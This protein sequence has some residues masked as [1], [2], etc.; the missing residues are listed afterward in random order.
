MPWKETVAVEL[1]AALVLAM[2]AGEVSVW[3][4]WRLPGYADVV[5]NNEE[6]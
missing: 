4:L 1:R 2:P 3:E 5:R 6:D